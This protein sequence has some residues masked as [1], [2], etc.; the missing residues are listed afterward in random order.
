MRILFLSRHSRFYTCLVLALAGGLLLVYPFI[1]P[2]DQEEDPERNLP[3]RPL[4]EFRVIKSQGVNKDALPEGMS[5]NVE[6]AKNRH[7]SCK[8]LSSVSQFFSVLSSSV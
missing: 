7:G 3:T 1:K 6:V 5:D 4:Y 2:R 8:L